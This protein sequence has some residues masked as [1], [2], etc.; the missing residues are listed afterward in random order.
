MATSPRKVGRNRGNAGKG[1]PKGV[2]NRTTRAAREA[3]QLAFD[4]AGGVDDLIEWAKANRT[5]F[6]KIYGRL[7]PTEVT[8][9]NGGPIEATIAHVWKFGSRE[10][11][12]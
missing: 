11:K 3:F 6:Y 2:P 5:E 8:G 9:A 1:R 7:I 4:G 12:F 10:V